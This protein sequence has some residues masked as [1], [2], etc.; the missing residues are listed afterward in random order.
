MKFFTILHI[1]SYFLFAEGLGELLFNGNCQ[2][3]HFKTKSISAPSIKIVQQRYKNAFK[4]EKQFVKYMTNF[5][6][7]PNSNISLMHDM[8]DKYELMPEMVFEQDVVED[9]SKYIY[10][11]HF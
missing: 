3:C 7:K 6:L 2:T 5:V 11:E 1:T 8:I 9:I 10:N 4:T